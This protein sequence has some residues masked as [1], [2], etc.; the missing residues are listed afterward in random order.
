MGS[1]KSTLARLF[2]K[3]GAILV[4]ADQIGHEVI[5]RP[6]I[7]RELKAAFGDEIEGADG[8]LNRRELGRRAFADEANRER[9]NR[10]VH[11]PLEVELWK[12]IDR[13]A[14]PDG[15]NIVVVD[16]ALIFE[17]GKLDRFDAIVVVFAEE[18]VQIE[19]VAQRQH[20]SWSEIQKRLAAQMPV[21]EKV[22]QADFVVENNGSVRE[23]QKK[24]AELWGELVVGNVSPQGDAP[25]KK[26]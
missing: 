5:E 26:L 11:P 25:R 19:R 17:W 6:Q 10:I 2:E 13:A 20:L 3:R 4:D 21:V 9:L 23:L 18:Q 16:A 15:N 12:Q 1:G 24:A 22:K 7:R 8:S 14:G